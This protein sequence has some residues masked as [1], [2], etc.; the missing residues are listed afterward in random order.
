MRA[1]FSRKEPKIEAKEF[2]VEKV[3]MLPAGEYES[4]TNHLMHRHD[5]IRENVDFMYEKDGVRHCLLVTGEGMEEGVL[6]ESEG[7][8]YARYFAFVPSVS[9]ILEQEQA[10]KETQTLSMIKESGQEE[11]AVREYIES[12]GDVPPAI[13]KA[14]RQQG[15]NSVASG[16]AAENE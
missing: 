15:K 16:S 6:V 5:F 10:V 9:G 11:Q 13:K 1:V 7:S 8:S 2:C 14:N 3:I 4:F 12:R